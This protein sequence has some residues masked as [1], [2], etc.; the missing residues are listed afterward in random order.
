MESPE[1][2]PSLS[3]SAHIAGGDFAGCLFHVQVRSPGDRYRAP[4]ARQKSNPMPQKYEEE[5]AENQF[6]NIPGWPP[7]PDWRG[8]QSFPRPYSQIPSGFDK[9]EL[10]VMW[11]CAGTVLTHLA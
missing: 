8:S 11:S 3:V 2:L 10:A 5:Q 7:D 4:R 9:T 1:R 6:A